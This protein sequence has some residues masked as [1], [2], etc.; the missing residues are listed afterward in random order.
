MYRSGTNHYTKNQYGNQTPQPQIIHLDNNV[1]TLRA[2][3][4]EKN[5]V[6]IADTFFRDMF[7][8]IGN[9]GCPVEVGTRHLT[10]TPQL[11][12]PR[13]G[14]R[15]YHEG[16]YDSTIPQLTIRLETILGHLEFCYYFHCS[17]SEP[18]TLTK[19]PTSLEH[20]SSYNASIL[21]QSYWPHQA[22]HLLKN[23]IIKK[24]EC[25]ML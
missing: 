15:W 1:H 24:L 17:R 23:T 25:P 9:V 19:G 14:R 13:I 16:T 7:G 12:S 22:Q 8:S 6:S 11:S 20:R 2:W 5:T 18:T 10:C 3:S 4:V 21:L